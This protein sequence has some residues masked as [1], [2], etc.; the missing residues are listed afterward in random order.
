MRSLERRDS[1]AQDV[2]G[3]GA[4]LG[5]FRPGFAEQLLNAPRFALEMTLGLAAL[6]ERAV[7]VLRW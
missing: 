2:L 1:V 4:A 3:L 7:L 6:G 5:P